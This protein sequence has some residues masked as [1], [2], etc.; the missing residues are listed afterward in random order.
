MPDPDAARE[1]RT[2]PCA[3][4]GDEDALYRA[5]AYP[6]RKAVALRTR[7]A[8]R[9]QVDDAC[10]TA[11][12]ILLRAQPHRET[13]F[14]WLVV[15]A[16]Y[17]AWRLVAADDR[18]AP[19]CLDADDSRLGW[20]AIE[21]DPLAPMHAR[22]RLRAVAAALPERKRHMIALLAYGYSYAEIATLTGATPRT[23]NR[24]LARAKRRLD[25][26]RDPL[27]A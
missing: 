17:E 16:T 27:A 23:V 25:P 26:L 11:W 6:L 12:L 1:R 3:L 19:L 20:L 14:N 4:R 2:S 7:G 22:E 10:A 18:H 9:D 13:A 24:Q 15:V 8:S 5:Y 21:N